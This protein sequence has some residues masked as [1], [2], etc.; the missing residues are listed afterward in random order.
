MSISKLDFKLAAAN[1]NRIL[2]GVFYPFVVVAVRQAYLV[3]VKNF[4]IGFLPLCIAFAASYA[5]EEYG[6]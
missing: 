6:N 1:G 5:K 2:S 3:C 4:V